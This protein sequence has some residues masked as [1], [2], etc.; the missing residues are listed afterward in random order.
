MATHYRSRHNTSANSGLL[1]AVLGELSA[2]V[3]LPTVLRIADLGWKETLRANPLLVN[4]MNVS[5]GKV[6]CEAMAKE[7]G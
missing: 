6:A 7:L 1:S 5:G 3:T 2:S 4:G